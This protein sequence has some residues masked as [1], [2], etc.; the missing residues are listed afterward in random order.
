MPS[1]NLLIIVYFLFV[2]LMSS[3]PIQ[4]I[5]NPF[6]SYFDLQTR[7]ILNH[8]LLFCLGVLGVTLLFI[9]LNIKRGKK[10]FSGYLNFVKR[11]VV[12]FI[13][14]S[15]ISLILLFVIAL[16]EVNVLSTLTY[17]NSR[18]LGV[19]TDSQV[20]VD[21]IK[22]NNFPPIVIAGGNK[23]NVL[24]LTIAVAE[25]GKNSFYGS[26]IVPF[27]PA[28]LTVPAKKPDTGVLMV[29]NSLIITELNSP[30]FQKISPIVSHLMINKYFLG[31]NARSYPNVTL[32]NKD[33]YLSYR[34]DD[35]DSKLKKFDELIAQINEDTESLS[36]GVEDLKTQVLENQSKLKQTSLQKEKEYAKCINTGYYKSETF[37]KT[38]SKEYCQ[39]KIVPLEDLLKQIN[40]EG[41]ELNATLKKNQ[42]K[43]TQYQTYITFYS[44]QKLLTQEESTFISY[45]FGTFNPP[46]AIKISLTLKNNLQATGDYFELL[47]HEY[48]HYAC[49]DENGKT[50]SSTFFKEGLTEYFAR[51]IIKSNLGVDT[52][53]GYPV[54]VKI[55]SQ[56]TKR[57]A[58]GDLA[59]IYF[60]N[61][62][63]GLE[64]Q[65]DRVYG[66]GFYKNNLVLFETLQFSSDPKQILEIANNI[67]S[68]IGGN[69][70]S[71]EDLS[72]T[73]STFQ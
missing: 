64:K 19:E 29:G 72:T 51:R 71:E 52:N 17:V 14:G 25:S 41:D 12:I 9:Y 35:F 48:L 11:T 43:L 8:L 61:D 32:M 55:I 63:A 65:L 66:T 34:K 21:R 5:T 73:Y 27:I 7:F 46:D 2:A 54:N 4:N 13:A 26:R 42:L 62:Q 70:L 31:R 20:I 57:I 45:E 40:I 69:P 23:D 18:L 36:V 44:Q 37:F 59:D 10:L 67:M 22:R 60:A 38:Y 56:I 24:P 1:F 58:E 33:E 3:I 49:F 30:E 6:L 50:I 53:L 16:V 15:L 28:Y 68:E 39:E 47:V